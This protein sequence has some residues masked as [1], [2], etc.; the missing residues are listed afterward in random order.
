MPEHK[1][2][3]VQILKNHYQIVLF[4]V[5]LTTWQHLGHLEH[6][7]HVPEPLGGWSGQVEG[8]SGGCEE[9]PASTSK[10]VQTAPK[11]KSRFSKIPD[12]Y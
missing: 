9:N 10:S 2:V 8:D 4:F 3:F 12:L 1:V 6:L 7:E 5:L 11:N